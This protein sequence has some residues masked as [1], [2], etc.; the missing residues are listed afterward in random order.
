MRITFFILIAAFLAGVILPVMA[1]GLGE[2]SSSMKGGRA[3]GE[4]EGPEP[5]PYS[6]QVGSSQLK[7]E[8]K[9]EP[10]PAQP[11][12]RFSTFM[13]SLVP[14]F[15]RKE[16]PKVV[17]QKI[18]VL[19]VPLDS[20]KA[21]IQGS[22]ASLE[23]WI[24]EDATVA[25]SE[26]R[27]VSCE[28]AHYLRFLRTLPDNC[29]VILYPNPKESDSELQIISA[30]SDQPENDSHKFRADFWDVQSFSSY[31]VMCWWI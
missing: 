9:P 8:P 19:I 29:V 11:E 7:P 12:G 13:K 23:A 16:S 17:A 10:K 18:H 26:T 6:S 5:P 31:K 15:L 4:D 25:Y 30:R 21:L 14:P 28:T 27:A 20:K 22:G 3:G 2:S 24:Y 1:G